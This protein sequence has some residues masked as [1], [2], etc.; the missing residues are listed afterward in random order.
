[1]SFASNAGINGLLGMMNFYHLPDSYLKDYMSRIDSVKLAEVNE[2]LRS[3]LDTD[4]F[5]I[6][7]V[8]ADDPWQDKGD[9]A[10]E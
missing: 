1:M 2:T 6:V 7:T 4:K 8:G 9:S 10:K 3:T 5:L